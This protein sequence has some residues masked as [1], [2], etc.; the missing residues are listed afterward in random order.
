[1]NKL[2]KTYEDVQAM[3]PEISIPQVEIPVKAK[4]SRCQVWVLLTQEYYDGHPVIM[5]FHHEHDALIKV[6]E[7]LLE[8][9]SNREYEGNPT[10]GESDLIGREVAV[11][12]DNDIVEALS[13]F[14]DSE[15]GWTSLKEIDVQ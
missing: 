12:S 14:W 13:D 3:N 4:L 8:D 7:M 11:I 2:G 9:R 5:T 1:M 6:R 10:E 15:G